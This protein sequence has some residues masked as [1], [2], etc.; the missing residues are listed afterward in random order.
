M[1]IEKL[2]SIAKA[3]YEQEVEDD[4]HPEASPRWEDFPD[5][6]DRYVRKAM[7]AVKEMAPQWQSIENAPLGTEIVVG[8]YVDTPDGPFWSQ[9]VITSENGDYGNDGHNGDAPTHWRPAPMPPMRENMKMD[10]DEL[11]PCLHCGGKAVHASRENGATHAGWQFEVDHW[12][13]C[14]TDDCLMSYGMCETKEEAVAGWN[15]QMHKDAHIQTLEKDAK[16]AEQRA[17][18]AEHV[19]KSWFDLRKL[20][21][22]QV[23]QVVIDS[24]RGYLRTSRSGGM[25]PDLAD[26][27]QDIVEDMARLSIFADI[28]A[29]LIQSGKSDD[30]EMAKTLAV[31]FCQEGAGA[32]NCTCANTGKFNCSDTTS[33]RLAKVAIREMANKKD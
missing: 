25:D 5:H 23:N 33:G 3:I 9:W 32:S 2:T 29:R 19:L 14:S 28:Y 18:D 26:A 17:E 22:E 13:Y 27:V 11:E 16:K 30:A 8:C 7:A 6:H 21:K 24:T 1:K 31:A 10:A 4:P 12:V 15:R 20:G